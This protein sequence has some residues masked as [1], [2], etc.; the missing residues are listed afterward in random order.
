VSGVVRVMVMVEDHPHYQQVGTVP[1]RDFERAARQRFT[2]TFVVT[3]SDG[4]SEVYFHE[5]ETVEI[6]GEHV[7]NDGHVISNRGSGAA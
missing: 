7:I 5:V 3:F 4:P 2:G 6:V 1:L